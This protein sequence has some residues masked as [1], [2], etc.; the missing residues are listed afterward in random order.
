MFFLGTQEEEGRAFRDD[1]EIDG[2]IVALENCR[3]T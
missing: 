1:R 2:A 3:G